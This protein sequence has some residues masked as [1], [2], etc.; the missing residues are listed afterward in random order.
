[1]ATKTQETKQN[2]QLATAGDTTLAKADK[3]IS[4]NFVAKVEKQFIA[5]IGAPI[6]WNSLHRALAQHLYVKIDAQLQALEVKRS[7]SRQKAS[8]PP[9]TWENINMTKLA[10]DATQIVMLELDASL[11]GHVYP[12][13]YLNKRTKKYDLDLQVGYKG[14]D[15]VHRKFAID[16]PVDIVYELVHETDKFS[17]GRNDQGIAWVKHERTNPFDPGKVIGGFGYI[18]YEDQRKNRVVIVEQ[19]EFDKA[20]KGAKSNDFWGGE[21]KEWVDGKLVETG[22]DEKF[23]KEMQFKTVVRRVCKTIALD[24]SKINTS[25]LVAL[26]ESKL[27]AIDDVIDAEVA[28]YANG[29][30]VDVQ[31]GEV[32]EIGAGTVTEQPSEPAPAE[33][34]DTGY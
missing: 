1:M 32:L 5:E 23:E 24:S 26:E 21:Q 19:R 14:V 15:H 8:D 29:E 18:T 33:E 28:E 16:V 10:I 20:R 2:G 34:E 27:D 13:P 25:N 22:F 30:T 11:S 9:I 4:Q 17:Y 7:N 12:I 31:T 3:T 6:A